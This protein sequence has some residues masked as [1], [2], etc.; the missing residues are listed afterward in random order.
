M[1]NLK[2]TITPKTPPPP[3]V[4][5]WKHVSTHPGLYRVVD[6]WDNAIFITASGGFKDDNRTIVFTKSG[7]MFE[8][9]T[10][11]AWSMKSFTQI[12]DTVTLVFNS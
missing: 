6:G 8:M 3:P 12:T 11:D 5:D 4:V 10:P 9:A 1:M 7:T 2:V